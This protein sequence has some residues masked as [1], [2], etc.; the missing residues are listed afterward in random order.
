MGA[1]DDRRFLRRKRARGR[2]IK[3]AEMETIRLGKYLQRS[4]HHV[5]EIL[6]SPIKPRSKFNRSTEH[7][8]YTLEP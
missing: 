4:R 3:R 6:H 2:H 1:D 5:T 8:H 7:S